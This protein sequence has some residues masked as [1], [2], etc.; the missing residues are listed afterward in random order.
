[1]EALTFGNFREALKS[2]DYCCQFLFELLYELQRLITMKKKL[3]EL[4]DK[5]SRTLK[6]QSDRFFPETTSQPVEKRAF[7]NWKSSRVKNCVKKRRKLFAKFLNSQ[8]ETNR[9][10]YWKQGKLCTKRFALQN[11]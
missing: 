1:M 5:F 9:Q 4:F 8:N 2:D 6:N 10:Q 7:G 3:D 11:M